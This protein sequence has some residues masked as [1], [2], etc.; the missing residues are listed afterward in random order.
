MASAG[1]AMVLSMWSTTALEDVAAAVPRE[2][3]LMMQLNFVNNRKKTENVVR[4]AEAA[5]HYMAI[6][7]T[8]DQSM[9]GHKLSAIRNPISIPPHLK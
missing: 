6:V 7:L 9:I 5:G 2:T 3:P 8:V 4:R 1:S